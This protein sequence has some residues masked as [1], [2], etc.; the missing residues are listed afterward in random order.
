M[1]RKI[2]PWVLFSALLLTITADAQVIMRRRPP[3]RNSP[4]Q[5]ERIRQRLPKFEPTVNLSIGYGFPNLDKDYFPVYYDAY[6][7]SA[8]QK[9]PITAALDY[10]FSRRMSIGLMVTHGTVSA[11]YYD[12]YNPSDVPLF[13]SKY[14][15][16][17]VMVNLTRY[18]PAG[19]KVTP[20]IRTA[21]GINLW[22]QEYTDANHNQINMQDVNLPDLAY[23]AG[24]GV[25]FNLSKKAGLFMEAGYGKYILQ[26][27][28]AVKF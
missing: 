23:Q 26:G 8:T 7:G 28:L 3:G 18:I 25:K 11:P 27:G 15:N 6:R 14:E 19:K 4:R 5:Q 22:E 24:M 16:W 9:G 2:L 13:Y 1:N 17:S 21:I 10:Q 20:Y 12:Y